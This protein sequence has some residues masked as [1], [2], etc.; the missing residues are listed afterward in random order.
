M[1]LHIQHQTLYNSFKSGDLI[2]SISVGNWALRYK[3]DMLIEC[4]RIAI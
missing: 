1:L 4:A 2:Y 3:Q